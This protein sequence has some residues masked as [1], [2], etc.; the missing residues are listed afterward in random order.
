MKLCEIRNEIDTTQYGGWIDSN[1]LEIFYV[2]GAWYHEDFILKHFNLDR[3]LKSGLELHLYAY[4]QGYIRF[5]S[6]DSEVLEFTGTKQSIL[7]LKQFTQFFLTLHPGTTLS[8]HIKHESVDKPGRR[9]MPSFSS[10]D[11]FNMPEHKNKLRKFFNE[12][13]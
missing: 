4:D 8:F 7:K 13:V 9:P 1:T 2:E 11:R 6:F 3:Q 5:V 12:I 10:N